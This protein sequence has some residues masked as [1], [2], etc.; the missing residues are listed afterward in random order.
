M[1]ERYPFPGSDNFGDIVNKQ[2]LNPTPKGFIYQEPAQQV[3]RNYISLPTSYENILLYHD[4]GS[5][6]TCTSISIA[7]GFKEYIMNMGKRIVVLV[8]N[9]NIQRN[10]VNEL[11]SK[12]TNNE[13]LTP[14]E[15]DLYFGSNSGQT[16]ASAQLARERLELA[17]RVHR[18]VNKTYTFLTYGSFVNRVLGSKNFAKD[19]LG[20]RTKRVGGTGRNAPSNPIGNF[21]NTVVIVDEAHNVTNND[22]YLALY[23]VLARSVNYRL[24]LLT[25][26]PIYDNSKEMFEISNLLNVHDTEK[27]LPIRNDLLKPTSDGEVLVAKAVSPHIN[28]VLKGGI[29]DVTEQGLDRLQQA[30]IGKVSRLST[31][32]ATFPRTVVRGEELLPGRQGTTRVVY[33]DMSKT[34]YI[35]YLQALKIDLKT[36]VKY[37]MSTV[38]ELEPIGEASKTSSLYKNCSDASTMSFPGQTF[39]KNGYEDAFLKNG[40]VKYPELFKGQL[41]QYSNKLYNLLQNIEASQGNVFV[42][43]NYVSFGGTALV[44]QLLL[45]NGYS[46][47]NPRSGSKS[48]K[49]FVLFDESTNPETREKIRRVFNSSEN[50]HGRYIK[51]LIGSPIISEGIT[52]KNIRQVHILEPSW[53]MSRINQIIGRAV[54]NYSHH[55]LPEE[56]RTVDIFKY[57]SIYKHPEGT[58]PANGLSKFFIDKEKY[59]LSE[60]KD[61]ANKK[62]ER[63]LKTISFDCSKETSRRLGLDDGSPECD[64][65]DCDYQCV[66]RPQN[67]A[68]SKTTYDLYLERFEKYDIEY[69]KSVVQ[70]LFSLTFV[71]KLSDIMNVVQKQESNIS[72]EVVFHTLG[73]MVKNQTLVMDMYNR[74]GFVVNMGEFYVFNPTG[75][76][77]NTSMYG[78]MFDFATAKNKYSLHEFSKQFLN[79]DLI[80]EEKDTSAKVVE[81]RPLSPADLA[82][83]NKMMRDNDVFGTFRQRGTKAKP[84]GPFDNVFRIV[85][86]RSDNSDS[87]DKRRVVSGMWIGSFKKPELLKLAKYLEIPMPSNIKTFDKEQIGELVQGFMVKNRL[88]LK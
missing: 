78:K 16:V 60:E 43:S 35:A 28:K 30:L 18:M 19:H 34:Q 14:E 27:L 22:V 71:W 46:E 50:K 9:K 62:V 47:Y 11:L 24:V 8:K 68:V 87:E 65:Q 10:F 48:Y 37:D 79:V 61:R 54:R 20:Q 6:K 40:E 29:V 69:V 26:T 38:A 36:D 23:S 85:D 72:E 70:E 67:T 5:G 80:E 84:F 55:D 51:V 1:T 58:E 45:H 82:F 41:Q 74:E 32:T 66:V 86:K 49:S 88:V 44:R 39:G 12:C 33:C 56:E 77:V 25:A 2:E 42:Y 7:E 17:N 15:R 75:I 21:N 53:N 4:L 83:N 52:L 59:V 73:N 3:L 31:N 76:D 81:E 64:Y 63:L 13:Y 57:V